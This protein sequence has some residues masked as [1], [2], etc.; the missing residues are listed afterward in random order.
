[1]AAFVVALVN[2]GVVGRSPC[3]A[4]NSRNREANRRTEEEQRR[5]E[6]TERAARRARIQNRWIVLQARY[7]LDPSAKVEAAVADF[8]Q[9]LQEYGEL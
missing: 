2:F 5:I 8:I 3:V 1:V 9:F 7:L 4:W 6:E